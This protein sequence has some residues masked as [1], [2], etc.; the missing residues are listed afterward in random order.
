MDY[1]TL[2]SLE[3]GAKAVIRKLDGGSEFQRRLRNMGIREEKTL[4]LVAKHSFHGPIVIEIDR[5][6]IAVGCGMAKKIAVE[7]R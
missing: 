4:R 6:Q 5:R 2:I 1:T 7:P 3:E